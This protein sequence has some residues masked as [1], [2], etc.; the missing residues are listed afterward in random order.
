[1]YPDVAALAR[2]VDAGG[3][4]PGLVVLTGPGRSV[5]WTEPSEQAEAVRTEL[6]H[7]LATLRA[8]LAEERLVRFDLIISMA[9]DMCSFLGS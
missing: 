7:L 2:S 8:W 6:T 3:V 4:A 5:S 1:V 9:L